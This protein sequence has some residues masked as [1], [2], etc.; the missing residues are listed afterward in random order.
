MAGTFIPWHRNYLNLHKDYEIY[1]RNNGKYYFDIAYLGTY[2]F[3]TREEAVD[4]I[5][6]AK[7]R[8]AQILKEIE[9]RNKAYYEKIRKQEAELRKELHE[10]KIL[11]QMYP[12]K[13]GTLKESKEITKSKVCHLFDMGYTNREVQVKLDYLSMQQISA[14]RVNYERRLGL[15]E[16]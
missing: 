14:F 16:D 3:N 7:Q 1:Q 8:V 6:P 2:C 9:I 4:G 11:E 15:Q 10:Q 13:S 5:K 12:E